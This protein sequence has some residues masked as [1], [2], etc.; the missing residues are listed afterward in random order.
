MGRWR[1]DAEIPSG[2]NWAWEVSVWEGYSDARACDDSNKSVR[3]RNKARLPQ[4]CFQCSSVGELDDGWTGAERNTSVSESLTIIK[5]GSFSFHLPSLYSS[6]LQLHISFDF[7]SVSFG[8]HR[9]SL[10][11]FFH[12]FLVPPTSLPSLHFHYLFGASHLFQD[13]FTRIVME[14]HQ[15]L[16]FLLILTFIHPSIHFLFYY[17]SSTSPLSHHANTDWKLPSSPG[18]LNNRRSIQMSK[19]KLEKSTSTAQQGLIKQH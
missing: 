12:P 3:Q 1:R 15:K 10:L 6:H 7:T 2:W 4:I 18:A 9:P 14:M 8:F 19:K 5:K 17:L 16:V 11:S 13:A